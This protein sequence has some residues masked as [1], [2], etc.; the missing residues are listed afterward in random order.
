[1][2][3]PNY[4]ATVVVHIHPDPPPTSTP[5]NCYGTYNPSI[6]F[7]NGDSMLPTPPPSE[8]VD[9]SP[10]EPKVRPVV[11]TPMGS[12]FYNAFASFKN[13]FLRCTGV[14]W[15]F[16][17]W[18]NLEVAKKVGEKQLRE[19][20]YKEGDRGRIYELGSD[21]RLGEVVP[22]EKSESDIE[23]E[24]EDMYA[25]EDERKARR[26]QLKRRRA[27]IDEVEETKSEPDEKAVQQPSA[28]V[29]PRT[30]NAFMPGAN[31]MIP[32][33]PTSRASTPAPASRDSAPPP[34]KLIKPTRSQKYKPN[35]TRFFTYTLP[36]MVAGEPLGRISSEGKEKYGPAQ[37][38]D[39]EVIV[40]GGER[41]K[42]GPSWLS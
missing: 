18:G 19:L 35:N 21:Q 17:V 29:L 24:P 28:P 32:S 10:R 22:G 39:G 25:V 36:N 14:E 2:A 30:V 4:Y 27:N 11:L 3:L 15:D 23:I 20:E 12:P 9:L 26:A 5:E 42:F 33:K 7:R 31:A 38:P 16:R 6:A 1:M 37:K 8:T 34:G 41:K 40:G 13:F